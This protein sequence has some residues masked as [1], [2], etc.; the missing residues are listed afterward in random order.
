[1]VT[2]TPAERALARAYS[3]GDG[4]I[5]FRVSELSVE[6]HPDRSLT[7]T[8]RLTVARPGHHDERWEFAL[9]WEDKSFADVFA[10]PSPDPD[11]L[12]VLVHLVRSLLEEWWDTKGRNRQSAKM[13]RRLP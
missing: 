13:G 7:L 3:T 5:S 12:G 11:R 6:H 4:R 10:S 1:M 8:Y 2:R 9:P